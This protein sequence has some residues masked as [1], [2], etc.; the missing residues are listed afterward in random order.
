MCGVAVLSDLVP[1]RG[2]YYWEIEVDES[3]EFLVGVAYEDTQRNPY[4]C[5]NNTSWCTGHILTPSRC[6]TG[7][8]SRRITANG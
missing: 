5:G 6:V 3:A 7:A 8:P 4:L 1:V 2:Q